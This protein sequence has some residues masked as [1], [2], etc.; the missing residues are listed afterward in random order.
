MHGVQPP[1]R[2]GAPE[3]TG[4]AHACRASRPS[5]STHAGDRTDHAQN[6][7]LEG[8][9]GGASLG[10]QT[11]LATLIV[12]MVASVG[13]LGWIVWW[14]LTT[15]LTAP[16]FPLPG[17][18]AAIVV[19]LWSLGC[20]RVVR[21]PWLACGLFLAAGLTV[22]SA[23]TVLPAAPLLGAVSAGL[24]VWALLG[25]LAGRRR[26]DARRSRARR[27]RRRRHAGSWRSTEA[28]SRCLICHLDAAGPNGYC[29]DCRRWVDAHP[30]AWADAESAGPCPQRTTRRPVRSD[31]RDATGR[32]TP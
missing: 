13:V 17:V 27:W 11:R 19:L 6:P 1:V 10:W 31:A 26:L 28:S 22:G 3:W 5:G 30:Q 15:S 4:S 8:A 7:H 9:P 16:T 29:A 32:E 14:V 25:W 2:I 21:Q 20:L 12:G 18:S 24:A 23:A